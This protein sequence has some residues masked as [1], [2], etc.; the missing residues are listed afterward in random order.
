MD[1]GF[2]GSERQQVA[3]RLL[4]GAGS[5]HGDFVKELIAGAQRLKL[6]RTN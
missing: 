4:P 6:G 1:A 2:A 3:V 5:Q